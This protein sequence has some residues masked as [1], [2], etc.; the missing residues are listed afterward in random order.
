MTQ[1]VIPGG[2]SAD[3]QTWYPSH[4]P[5]AITLID[6]HPITAAEAA[7]TTTPVKGLG[8]IGGVL[9][10]FDFHRASGGTSVSAWLQTS[11]DGTTWWDVA[12]VGFTTSSAVKVANV[13]AMA[14][15]TG[16]LVLTD[17]SLAANSVVDG[18]L[19]T[20]FRV[21]YTSVGTYGAGTYLSVKLVAV[22]ASGI[23]S[24]IAA[25]GQT[26]AA[27]STPVVN[28]SDGVGSIQTVT[29]AVTTTG[30]AGSATGTADSAAIYGYLIDV[31]VDW[32]ASAPATSDLLLLY[33]SPSNGQI[34]SVSNSATDDF[35]MPLM[36]A[37]NPS[38]VDLGIYGRYALNGT[39]Q[40]QVSGCDALAPAVTVRLRY[41]KAAN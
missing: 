37:Q 31:L 7:A 23:K 20:Q 28:A 2:P 33:L 32:H 29:L 34:L 15:V 13:S 3:L 30:S 11:I 40:V 25:L 5:D 24:L 18:A 12:A 17:G 21:K 27:A 10:V 6:Q 22:E 1:K 19:G 39:L 41:A 36:Q 14:A 38:G 16:A 26:T 9:A 4:H 8:G 35:F